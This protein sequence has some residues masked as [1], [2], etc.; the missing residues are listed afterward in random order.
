MGV[1]F[2]RQHP[3]EHY[4]L[5][6]YCAERKLAIEIDGGQHS[7]NSERTRD[8]QR[9]A[10]LRMRGIRVLRF[11][12]N[13]VFENPEGVWEIIAAAL[14]EQPLLQPSPDGG[15]SLSVAHRSA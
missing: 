2:R 6:F 12:N 13:E 7:E 3:L 8:A 15:G 11:W 9:T 1:K 10:S 5:D 4:V 14:Q